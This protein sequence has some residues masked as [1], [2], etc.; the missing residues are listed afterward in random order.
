MSQCE[1]ENIRDLVQTLKK[2]NKSDL[3]IL[4]AGAKMLK[5]RQDLEKSEKKEN[6]TE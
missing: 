2:L 3:I 5:A 4:D 1:K 6:D